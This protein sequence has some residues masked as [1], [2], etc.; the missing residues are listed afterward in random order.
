MFR[1]LRGKTGF[2]R[3]LK[4]TFDQLMRQWGFQPI[5]HC[6][7]RYVLSSTRYSG[8][9]QDLAGG[10]VAV[11]EFRVETARDL[12]LVTPLPEGAGLIS[13]R[14]ADGTF[15]H[16]LNTASGFQRKLRQLGISLPK[17]AGGASSAAPAIAIQEG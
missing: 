11:F 9:P 17:S 5:R 16:T 6:P 12:V 7:G 13:Y 15:L 2:S 8:P 10:G 4:V 3:E 1:G 14:R